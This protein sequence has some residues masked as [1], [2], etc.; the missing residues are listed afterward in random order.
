MY[1]LSMEKFQ[2][3]L[4]QN[5]ETA[6]T[7]T[8][9]AT[10]IRDILTTLKSSAQAR[11]CANAKTPHLHN[12]ASPEKYSNQHDR[13][14][15]NR[16]SS[17][18]L[19]VANGLSQIF[20]RL[21]SEDQTEDGHYQESF[22]VSGSFDVPDIWLNHHLRGNEVLL[23][24]LNT[25][26]EY[27]DVIGLIGLR[28]IIDDIA[29]RWQIVIELIEEDNLFQG[30][31]L[32]TKMQQIVFASLSS[33][34]SKSD[35]GVELNM[36]DLL[37]MDV[38]GETSEKLSENDV[39][40]MEKIYSANYFD[41][42]ELRDILLEKFRSTVKSDPGTFVTVRFDKEII[43]YYELDNVGTNKIHFGKFNVTPGLE[44]IGIG[45]MLLDERL[46][47][48]AK[49]NIILAEC[50][51]FAGV[52]RNYLKNGFIGY[53]TTEIG[54]INVLSIARNDSANNIFKSKTIDANEI[55]AKDPHT[56]SYTEE[57]YEISGQDVVVVKGSWYVNPHIAGASFDMIKRINEFLDGKVNNKKY[58]VTRIFEREINPEEREWSTYFVLEAI[59]EEDLDSYMNK[60]EKDG[61]H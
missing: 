52:S 48:D 41:K 19:G 6:P 37:K 16:Q 42:P 2:L 30:D 60:F 17:E 40:T 8:I 33:Y 55:Y 23:S 57:S 3:E 51:V 47:V 54:E 45:N 31:S 13:I 36:E 24:T 22:D 7:K 15:A 1:N 56:D 49:S 11:E 34:A 27:K 58:A 25:L 10:F 26:L 12:G 9:D 61:I 38:I 28:S 43:G 29:A 32:Y 21:Y 18:D 4:E 46:N 44:G 50:D 14:V 35:G 53:K 20:K 39:L 5:Q 59:K